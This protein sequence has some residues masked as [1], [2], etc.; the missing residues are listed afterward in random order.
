MHILAVEDEPAMAQLLYSALT[1]EGHVVTLASNGND[2]LQIALAGRFDLIVLD[3]MLP[4]KD[5]FEVTRQLRRA[6]AQTPLLILTARDAPR[7]MVRAL[8]EGADD[9]LIK[10]FSL[11]VFLARV[12]AV[13]RRGDIPQPVCLEASGLALNTASRQVTRA[14]RQITLTPREYS[15]LE[16][17]MRNKGRVLSRSSIVEAVWGF[18]ADIEENTLDAFIRL[19]RMKIEEPGMPRLI[20]TVRGVGY[21]IQEGE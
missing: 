19:L 6:H 10:P 11:D 8:D 5:G 7:D 9:Y 20:R 1:E 18:D 4:G 21:A 16:L 14:K 3:L 2:A 17:L 13:S 15:L 12:R